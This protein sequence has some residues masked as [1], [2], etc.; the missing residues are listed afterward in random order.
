M[1]TAGTT[2]WSGSRSAAV[3]GAAE[4]G[5]KGAGV[6]ALGYL[7]NTVKNGADGPAQTGTVQGPWPGATLCGPHGTGRAWWPGDVS[8]IDVTAHIRQ[9]LFHATEHFEWQHVEKGRSPP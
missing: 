6:A 4:D 1:A 3:T 9:T 7:S 8:G 2:P 5:A